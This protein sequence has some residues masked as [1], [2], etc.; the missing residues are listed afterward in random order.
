MVGTF[1]E[2]LLH[3]L[4]VAANVALDHIW[5]LIAVAALLSA[6]LV[7]LYAIDRE[8]VLGL[9]DR[10]R[11]Y[12]TGWAGW[13]GALAL[14]GFGMY[15]LTLVQA[16]VELRNDWKRQS[17]YSDQE[18][19]SY[20]TVYQQGPVSSYVQEKTFT[21]RLVLPKEFIDRLG[22]EGVSALAPYRR[23]TAH[24]DHD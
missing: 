18:S 7:T 20:G 12:F 11:G 5:A 10:L 1:L 9:W 4:K 19:L 22:G 2:S 6:I 23:D 14:T 13:M 16:T 24:E 17:P 8:R 21:R 15:A 3:G